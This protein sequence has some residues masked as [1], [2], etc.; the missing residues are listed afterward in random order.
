VAFPLA[1]VVAQRYAAPMKILVSGGGIAGSAAALFLARQAHTVRIVDRAPSF[2]KRGYAISLKHFGI[3]LM[4]ELGLDEELRRHALAY[5]KLYFYHS[6]GRPMQIMS[7]DLVQQATH[8]QIFTYRSEL[9][10]ILHEAVCASVA[11]P[12]FGVHI[13]ALTQD[14]R[15]V[16]VTLS[17]GTVEDFDLVVV[18]EGMRSTTR[19]LLWGAEGPEPIGVMY[20]AATVDVS[21]GLD[22][23]GVHG[24]VGK[25]HNAAFLPIDDRRLLMQC[26]WRAAG[27]DRP[28]PARAR[29]LLVDSFHGFGPRIRELLEAIPVDGDVFCDAVSMIVL[30]SLHR[31]RVVLVGDAGHCPTFLSGM[32]ASLGLLGAKLLA[33]SLGA[34]GDVDA[35]LSAYDEK[36]L[37]LVKHFQHNAVSNVGNLLPS[38][39]LKEVLMGWALHLLPPSLMAK[40][41]GKQ[42]AVEEKLLQGI[43]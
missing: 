32:G 31:G 25:E 41:F 30:P 42:F 1:S 22:P 6:D 29:A 20:A 40:Q 38:S 2:Q 28:D 16:R 10:A 15:A 9:H 14:A 19:Q 18:S 33:Q 12:R 23:H 24:Y 3:R 35:A 26:Y 13:A 7:A 8:G 21:H 39:H 5:D 11:P 43:V 17:D 37:P 4:T 34:T 27:G 36:L